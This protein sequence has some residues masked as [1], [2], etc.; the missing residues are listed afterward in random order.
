VNRVFRVKQQVRQFVHRHPE[1]ATRIE[2]HLRRTADRVAAARDA[3]PPLVRVDLPAHSGGHGFWMYG[4]EGADQIARYVWER[5]WTGFEWPLPDA[6]AA[7]VAGSSGSVI[8]VGANTGFYS[9]I[10][11]ACAPLV[12]VAALE[13]QP[14]VADHLRRNVAVNHA[15]RIE[16]LQVAAGDV[17]GSAR[18]YIPTS[19]H[20]LV[21]TSGSLDETF[22]EH[23]SAVIDVAV[24]TI[25]E[26]AAARP[27]PLVALKVDVEGVEDLVLRGARATLVEDRPVVFFE[28]LAHRPEP[29]V[30]IERLRRELGYVAARF[31]PDGVVLAA[32]VAVDEQSANHALVPEEKVDDWR[33]RLAGVPLTVIDTR[34][35]VSP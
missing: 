3:T 23:H 24:V 18:F 8:D 31:R 2:G 7:W 13:P 30:G 1:L 19:E 11:S 22:K 4:L 6:F 15:D 33:R 32:S 28:L 29:G 16:V 9:L 27:R 34:S 14:D 26:V 20:G 21:E 12:H 10:T 5:G 35:G 17:A 25:D